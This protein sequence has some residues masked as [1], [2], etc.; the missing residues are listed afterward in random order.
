MKEKGVAQYVKCLVLFDGISN[1]S[2]MKQ[3]EEIGLKVLTLDEVME[4]GRNSGVTLE[5]EKVDKD[6]YYMLNYTSGT[7]GDSKGVKVTHWGLLSS[8]WLG[9]DNMQM[10]ENDCYISYL[11][12]PHVFENFIYITTLMT[13]AKVGFY[14]GDPLKLVEDCG[15]LKP[16]LFPSVPRLYNKIYHRIE[17][18]FG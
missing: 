14:Q 15:V 17:T 13:G 8:A 2:E 10:T 11:P 6:D 12:A 16:T 9:V 1:E 18:Q 3:A 7:T 4:E 5:P